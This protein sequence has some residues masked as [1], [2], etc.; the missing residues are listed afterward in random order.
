LTEENLER[1][2]AETGS[3]LVY[4][5]SIYQGRGGNQRNKTYRRQPKNCVLKTACTTFLHSGFVWYSEDRG[6][7]LGRNPEK[8]F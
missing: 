1:L 6:R 3:L 5:P 8:K 7:I 4:F 2:Q